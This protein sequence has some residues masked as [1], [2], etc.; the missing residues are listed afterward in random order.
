MKKC[1]IYGKM[2]GAIGKHGAKRR[3]GWSLA[4]PCNLTIL[5]GLGPMG[6]PAGDSTG[7]TAPSLPLLPSLLFHAPHE[8][9]FSGFGDR[10]GG[11]R[12][13]GPRRGGGEGIAGCGGA[14]SRFCD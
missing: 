13:R 9:S 2:A 10:L 12:G 3:L 1:P 8:S 11:L 7:E 14:E 6:I 4:I 5:K